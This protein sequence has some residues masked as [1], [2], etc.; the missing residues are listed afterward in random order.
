MKKTCSQ[1]KDRARG[2]MLGHYGLPI[3]AMLITTLVSILLDIPF[4]RRVEQGVSY[5]L[6]FYIITGYAGTLLASLVTSLFEI[7]QRRIHL[8]ISRNYSTVFSDLLYGFKYRPDKFIGYWFLTMLISVLCLT[9]GIICLIIAGVPVLD[10]IYYTSA[11]GWEPSVLL[12]TGALLLLAGYI[13]YI[14][15]AL[16]FSLGTYLMLDD[17]DLGTTEAFRAS[18][19]YMK[20]NK[21]RL[22]KLYLS[23]IGWILLGILT[24]CI[25]FLWIF[26]YITQSL[27]QFYLDTVPP[28]QSDTQSGT[29][30]DTRS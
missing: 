18:F 23:F 9:P 14:I 1:L 11:S 6:P 13:V 29:Q 21:W 12:F 24:L 4:S 26:P 5:H 15:F 17:I 3:A 25:G 22:F 28:A 30:F 27:T 2:A 20:G 19:R 10:L 8:Q 16:G 7:G